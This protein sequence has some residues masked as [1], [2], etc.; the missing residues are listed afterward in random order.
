MCKSQCGLGFNR[1]SDEIQIRKFN[2][3]NRGIIAGDDTMVT[4]MSIVGRA[5]RFYGIIPVRGQAYTFGMTKDHDSW[6]SSLLE[7]MDECDLELSC[8]GINLNGTL[9]EQI[10]SKTNRSTL[11]PQNI[12]TLHEMNIHTFGDLTEMINGSLQWIDLSRL[13]TTFIA[14]LICGRIVP[15]ETLRLRQG[16]C[17]QCTDDNGKQCVYEYIGHI[18]YDTEHPELRKLMVRNG[19]P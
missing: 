10:L 7:R 1:L 8:G 6:L 12:T 3:L 19:S 15:Q 2:L 17:W 13:G 16:T 14:P 4:C 9:S 5:A 18:K 11:S